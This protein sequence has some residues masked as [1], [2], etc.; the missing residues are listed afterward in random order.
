MGACGGKSRSSLETL[1]YDIWC[2]SDLTKIS[3]ESYFNFFKRYVEA[4]NDIMSIDDQDEQIYS[5]IFSAPNYKEFFLNLKC[6]IIFIGNNGKLHL[7]MLALIFFT[8]A[9]DYNILGKYLDKLFSLIKYYF[10]IQE[11]I[12]TDKEFFVEVMDVYVLINTQ[13]SLKHVMKSGIILDSQAKEEEKHLT[14]CYDKKYRDML[15]K[16]LLDYDDFFYLSKF[17]QDNFE[18]LS[19]VNLRDQLRNLY[20]E[21]K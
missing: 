6:D 2:D 14:E 21:S 7:I 16:K 8:N 18:K 1:I 12:Q 9:K 10:E 3:P 13:L 5:T 19:P 11:E 17:L 4:S 20:Y 15:V